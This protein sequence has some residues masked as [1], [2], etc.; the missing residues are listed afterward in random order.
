M[1]HENL[2]LH[3]LHDLTA[4]IVSAIRAHHVGGHAGTALGT[5]RQLAGL[6]AMMRTARTRSR[7]GMLAFRNGHLTTS[8]QD[9]E[10]D[11]KPFCGN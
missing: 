3:N 9:A 2:R 7:I 10:R 11:H 5:E 6:L 4:H 1:R 8:A